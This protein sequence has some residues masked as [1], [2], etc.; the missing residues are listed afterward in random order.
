MS[1]ET[2][3]NDQYEPVWKPKLIQ[4]TQHLGPAA[5]SSVNSNLLP[6][7]LIYS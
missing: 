3:Q 2:S 6:Q 5:A 4:T 7:Q 1:D